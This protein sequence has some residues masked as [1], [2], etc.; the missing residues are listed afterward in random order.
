VRIV[1]LTGAIG[2][3][4]SAATAFFRAMG[5][6]VHDADATVHRLLQTPEVRAAL[7]ER[8]PFLRLDPHVDRHQLA[9]HVFQDPEALQWLEA[10]L[11]PLVG[12]SQVVFLKRQARL[13]KPLAVLDVPLLVETRQ[14]LACD[15]VV[16]MKV[17]PF[18][19]SKRVLS[20][21]GMTP[22][23]MQRIQASQ[24][25]IAEKVK[26]ADTVV[27]SGLHRGHLFRKLKRLFG[28]LRATSDPASCWKPGWKQNQGRKG[29][30]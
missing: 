4:K 12:S 29:N 17:Q 19:Q 1:G 2:S 23:L 5:V 14:H 26:K 27:V 20:R 25:T 16:V 28:Q 30:P 24:G 10:L 6:G 3:G 18:L 22:Q 9:T 15:W 8:F 7:R 11:H 21:K 13:R